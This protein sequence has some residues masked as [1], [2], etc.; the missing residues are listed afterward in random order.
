MADVQARMSFHDPAS[1]VS[2]LNR[3]AARRAVRVSPETWE[4]LSAAREAWKASGGAF[5][6]TVAPRLVRWGYLPP[7][8]SARR[9]GRG[10]GAVTLL[11]GF[12]VRF[13]DALWLDLGGIAKGYAVDR[14]CAALE[15]AGVPDY[16]VN[17]GGDLRIGRSPESVWVRH[18]RAPGQGLRL[19]PLSG[20]GVASS[21]DGFA[22]RRRGRRWVHPIV[23][24]A[25]GGPSAPGEGVTVISRS[26]M[27][28]DALTKVVAVLGEGAA[29]VLKRF[30]AAGLRFSGGTWSMLNDGE[31]SKH[32]PAPR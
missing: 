18:P 22:R 6:A 27:M 25:T 4:V 1:E 5:D 30:R 12:R 13:L 7:P 17:A 8:T 11:D 21:A 3:E 28:S 2:L 31:V 19:P 32:V 26:C 14:A 15:A 23:N 24:P 16:V 10:F 9:P 20:V 29:P